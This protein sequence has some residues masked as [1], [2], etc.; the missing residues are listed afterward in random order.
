MDPLAAYTLHAPP[1]VADC[2]AWVCILAQYLVTME[3]IHWHV[4]VQT[5]LVP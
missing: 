1:L 5:P 4:V 2:T 3:T